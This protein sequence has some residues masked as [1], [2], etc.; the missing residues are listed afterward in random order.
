MAVADLNADAYGVPR[1]WGRLALGSAALWREPLFGTVAYVDGQPAAGA[2]AVPI[3][4]ALYVA[5]VATAK[6]H[7]GQ[8]LAE[9]VI[10]NSLEAAKASTGMERTVL[11][12]TK[13]GFPV[14]LRMGYQ[15]VVRFPLYGPE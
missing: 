13:Y 12:A 2:F 15:S 14:Y 3:D 7:R 1:S 5:W 8:G 10:R 6:F 11:H 9:L 4:D